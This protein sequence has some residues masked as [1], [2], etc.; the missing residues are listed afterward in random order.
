MS[1]AICPANVGTCL[2]HVYPA[3]RPTSRSDVPTWDW[4]LSYRLGGGA[5]VA[6]EHF[7]EALLEVGGRDAA[8]QTASVCYGNLPRFLA[9]DDGHGVG[10][11]GDAESRAVAQAKRARDV[12]AVADGE[13]AARGLDAVV[14]DNHGAVVQGRVLEEDVLD[15]ARVDAGVDD[16]AGFGVA[17]ER[18]FAL[19]DDERSGLA[20]C[21]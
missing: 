19:D 4:P 9:D 6:G 21:H 13:D 17:L 8:G 15:E 2:W 5:A 7:V 11:L 14:G 3:G 20:L 10:L 1:L 12:I 18:H 16:V